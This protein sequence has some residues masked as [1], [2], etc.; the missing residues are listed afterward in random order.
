MILIRAHYVIDFY[1][2]FA[3]GMLWNLP[4]EKLSYYT[5]VV[6]FGIKKQRRDTY[7]YSACPKC[8]WLNDRAAQYDVKPVKAK[9]QA[10]PKKSARKASKTS[11]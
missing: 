1:G 5:D 9:K 11:K 4:A 6:M 7:H 2:G 10:T 8:G 3:I